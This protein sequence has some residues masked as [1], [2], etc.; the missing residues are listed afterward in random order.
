MLSKVLMNLGVLFF[1]YLKH[2]KNITAKQSGTNVNIAKSLKKK[3][4]DRIL[5]LNLPFLALFPTCSQNLMAPGPC[6]LPVLYST[7]APPPTTG[8]R[9][10]AALTLCARHLFDVSTFKIIDPQDLKKVH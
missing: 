9:R 5:S 2:L 1:F 6:S 10:A 3:R 8:L 4:Q 7:L